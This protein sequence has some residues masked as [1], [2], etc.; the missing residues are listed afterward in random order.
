[1][2]IT[3]D[4]EKDDFRNMRWC[5]IQNFIEKEYEIQFEYM[6][7]A[8]GERMSDNY[9]PICDKEI[10]DNELTDRYGAHLMCSIEIECGCRDETGLFLFCSECWKPCPYRQELPNKIEDLEQVHRQ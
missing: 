10:K 5:R 1:M 8:K 9:C 4:T 2:K 6:N 7:K 3:I